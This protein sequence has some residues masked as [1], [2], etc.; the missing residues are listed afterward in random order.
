MCKAARV[1]ASVI[2]MG[3]GIIARACTQA[4]R[5][6]LASMSF[7]YNVLVFFLGKNEFIKD[8]LYCVCVSVSYFAKLLINI[9]WNGLQMHQ[10]PGL[11]MKRHRLLRE[12]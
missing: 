8:S 9:V 10:K 1:L 2:V 7:N 11:R 5:Q 3:S 4:Y 6:A 12:G